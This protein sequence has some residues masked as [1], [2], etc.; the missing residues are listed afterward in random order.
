ML[1]PPVVLASHTKCF[2]LIPYSPRPKRG[3]CHIVS[4][5]SSRGF[6]TTYSLPL[7][8]V[9][10]Y[11]AALSTR[12]CLPDFKM[13]LANNAISF[14]E[15][16]QNNPVTRSFSFDV[17]SL[18]DELKNI[19]TRNAQPS[20]KAEMKPFIDYI[21]K[22]V[23]WKAAFEEREHQELAANSIFQRLSLSNQAVCSL[24]TSMLFKVSLVPRWKT[25]VRPRQ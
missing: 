10:L 17:V 11:Y 19:P 24:S 6:R 22:M 5:L 8:C 4:G 9:P 14:S 21:A 23:S 20:F 18:V 1:R 3:D 7:F 12:S 16:S 2:S 25:S 13:S 15:M